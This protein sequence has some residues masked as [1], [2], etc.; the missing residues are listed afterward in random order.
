M[1]ESEPSWAGN[2]AR[3]RIPVSMIRPVRSTGLRIKPKT[4]RYGR[5]RWRLHLERRLRHGR[6]KETLEALSKP[7]RHTGNILFRRVDKRGPTLSQ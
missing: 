3:R 5:R 1:A 4:P 7:A 6:C 2:R